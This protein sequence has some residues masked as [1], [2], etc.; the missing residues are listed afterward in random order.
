M[1]TFPPSI[2]KARNRFGCGF[3]VYCTDI[4]LHWQE[5]SRKVNALVQ[6]GQGRKGDAEN[7]VSYWNG[8]IFVI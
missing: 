5:G 1:M 2:K 8:T 4:S 3:I 6:Y 7:D